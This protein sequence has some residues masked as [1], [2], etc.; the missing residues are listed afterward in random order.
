MR[1]R[2]KEPAWLGMSLFV[3]EVLQHSLLPRANESLVN[4]EKVLRKGPQ[5]IN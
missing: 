1:K 4:L 3:L 5:E 2:R